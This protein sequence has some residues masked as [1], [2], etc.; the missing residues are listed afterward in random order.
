MPSSSSRS[1]TPAPRSG[2]GAATADNAQRAP[3]SEAVGRQTPLR[4]E[5]IARESRWRELQPAWDDLVRRSATPSIYSTWAFL[6]AT[7]THL[8]RPRGDELAVMAFFDGDTLVGAAP[9]RIRRRRSVLLPARCLTPLA[10]WEASRVPPAFGFATD[11]ELG[12]ALSAGIETHARRWDW[13]EVDDVDPESDVLWRLAEWAS[14]GRRLRLEIEPRPPSPYVDLSRGWE[15]VQQEFGRRRRSELRRYLRALDKAGEWRVDKEMGPSI[16]EALTGYLDV[17]SRSWKPQAGQ[18]VAR[19]DQTRSFYRALLPTLAS[20]GR[21]AI[22]F[23]RLRERRIASM[24]EFVLGDTIWGAQRTYDAQARRLAP[25][26]CL[27]SMVLERWA[28]QGMR[29]YELLAL[30]LEDKR[31]W[32]KQSHPNVRLRINQLRSVRQRVAFL[33]TWLR[34]LRPHE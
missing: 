24:I 21:V 33:R 31:H 27:A 2:A 32:T 34:T 19:N 26:N 7:W 3:R 8:A 11:S 23:L 13:L 6:E 9:F 25:G 28:N 29:A 30:F 14:H 5:W 15:G 20:E 1:A 17:E 18:G 4:I 10:G 16:G 22:H 12:A